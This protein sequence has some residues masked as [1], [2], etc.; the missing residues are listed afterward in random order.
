M[1]SG[2]PFLSWLTPFSC[3]FRQKALHFRPLLGPAPLPQL[4]LSTPSAPYETI[5]AARQEK[6]LAGGGLLQN[7][8]IHWSPGC[9]FRLVVSINGCS[10]ILNKIM[11]LFAPADSK[12]AQFAAEPF[13]FPLEKVQAGV[14]EFVGDVAYLKGLGETPFDDNVACPDVRGTYVS[15]AGVTRADFKCPLGEEQWISVPKPRHG[16]FDLVSLFRILSFDVNSILRRRCQR[17]A[18]AAA[19][20]IEPARH[21]S[22]YTRRNVHGFELDVGFGVPLSSDDSLIWA[23]L[24]RVVTCGV[25]EADGV[26]MDVGVPVEGLRVE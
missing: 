8:H 15:F 7:P 16:S 11:F 2:H 17:V 21:F 24:F 18:A 22:D 25:H 3:G 13:A 10:D 19:V 1:G 9:H 12:F 14:H 26:V 20:E 6:R 4:K 23:H 5:V